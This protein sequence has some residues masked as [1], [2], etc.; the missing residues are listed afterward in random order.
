[1]P[2][3]LLGKKVRCPKCKATFIAG[4]SDRVEPEEEQP[5]E[6]K[7]E[8]PA[9][10]AIIDKPVSARRRRPPEREEPEDDDSPRYEDEERPRRRRRRRRS[11]ATEEAASAVT[12]PAICLMVL[13]GIEVAFAVFGLLLA[14]LGFSIIQAGAAGQGQP[15][16]DADAGARLAGNIIGS[17]VT[18]CIGAVMIMGG[19]KMK[20]LESYGSVMTACIVSMVPCSICC[21]LGLPLGIWGLIVLNKPEVREAFS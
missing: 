13:G 11:F 2:A 5:A 18:T 15:G 4:G 7:E 14:L 21:L 16:V 12:P 8:R 3:T 1:L 20:R 17:V 6:P 10:E 19:Y 9:K